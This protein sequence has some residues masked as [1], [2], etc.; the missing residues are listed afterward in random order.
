VP[1]TLIA[2][3]D[4][5]GLGPAACQVARS[6]A[7]AQDG[8]SAATAYCDIGPTGAKQMTSALSNDTRPYILVTGY[9]PAAMSY[10]QI[11]SIPRDVTIVGPGRDAPAVSR[12]VISDSNSVNPTQAV[13]LPSVG[14]LKAVSLDGLELTA[15]SANA[16]LSCDQ[17]L[18]TFNVR[19]SL[20][21]G[22]RLGEGIANTAC[23]MTITQSA[24]SQNDNGIEAN[25]GSITIA[26]SIISD[27]QYAAI[28]VD[29]G[30]YDISN[31]LMFGNAIRGEM[32]INLI[33]TGRFYFNTVG[34]NGKAGSAGGVNC[35]AGQKLEASIIWDNA[36][37]TGTTPTQFLGNCSFISVVTDV[38][39][40][41][42][43]KGLQKATPV[44]VGAVL[45]D[46]TGN[47]FRLDV[48]TSA[49]IATNRMSVLDILTAPE[50][51]GISALP[52]FDLFN[53][54]RPQ[55]A[56][57]EIGAHEARY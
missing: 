6:A 12:A 35:L 33:A 47:D 52:L 25:A 48:S 27:N 49:N 13:E 50:V 43:T 24:I 10:T 2:L 11:A 34:H 1:A 15:T 9:G 38:N 54:R 3:V 18:L 37:T 29:G 41:L 22:N 26:Q 36:K 45:N 32:A 5:G 55:N 39:E 28:I 56:G 8:N 40:S 16:V 20:I 21:V 44:F 31:C 19:N 42:S 53:T 4:H 7:A 51:G 17:P 30:S 46:F 14:A 23:A 57:W